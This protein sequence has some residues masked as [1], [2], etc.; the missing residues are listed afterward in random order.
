M[1]M[2]YF[3]AIVM[4]VIMGMVT[5]GCVTTVKRDGMAYKT[6]RKPD[7]HTTSPDSDYAV[8]PRAHA[9]ISKNPGAIIITP[10]FTYI[11][12]Q[13]V[14]QSSIW[15]NESDQKIRVIFIKT[16]NPNRSQQTRITIEPKTYRQFVLIPGMQYKYRVIRLCDNHLWDSGTFQSDGL[17]QNAWS[18]MTQSYWA[19]VGTTH[20]P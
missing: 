11:P 2:K 5:I 18:E 7:L 19:F 16:S 15:E 9:I 3:L 17:T 6:Y 13:G 8:P 20:Q 4:V 14:G 1:K 12:N 10:N